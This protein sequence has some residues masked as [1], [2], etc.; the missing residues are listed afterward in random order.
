M[1]EI[2]EL[3]VRQITKAV[4]QLAMDANFYL[5]ED[6]KGRLEASQKNEKWIYRPATFCFAT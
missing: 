6:V 5:P 2:R 3:D 4:R 1:S